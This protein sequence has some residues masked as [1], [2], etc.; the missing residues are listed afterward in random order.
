[1]SYMKRVSSGPM[2]PQDFNGGVRHADGSRTLYLFGFGQWPLSPSKS[3]WTDI[4][5]R[6]NLTLARDSTFDQLCSS[7]KWARDSILWV[8]PHRGASRNK[9]LLENLNLRWQ[10]IKGWPWYEMSW[11]YD[12]ETCKL[13]A[14]CGVLAF[15]S[16]NI[17]E[18]IA[19]MG[20]EADKVCTSY[21][22]ILKSSHHGTKGVQCFAWV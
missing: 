13:L 14:G 18:P 21:C 17:T 1:M 20:S 6:Y 3:N 8:P 10:A 5:Q 2:W 22:L 7:P 11:R 9:R 19:L 15:S 12:R 16:R 4:T